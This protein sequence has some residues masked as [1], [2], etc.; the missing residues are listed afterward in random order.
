MKTYLLLDCNYLCH[1]AWHAFPKLSHKGIP[2]G[3]LFGFF[4]DLKRFQDD[5]DT[6][7]LIFCF[8]GGK[9]LRCKR[10]PNYKCSRKEKPKEL[11]QQIKWLFNL[12]PRLGFKNVWSH[13]GYEAD[14]LIAQACLDLREDQKAVIITGDH[15]FYQCIDKQVHV[16]HPKGNKLI[17]KKKMLDKYGV[18]P[19]QW[20]FIKALCGCKTDDIP[21]V[22][23]VQEKTA[24]NFI[25]GKLRPGTATHER[26][27][28]AVAILDRNKPLVNLPYPG[29]PSFPKKK[30]E[31][32]QEAWSKIARKLGIKSIRSLT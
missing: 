2:T 18:K 5:F 14:D 4:K 6:N 27:Q 22:P 13:P 21:G 11:K 20:A 1:R 10:F 3:V 28:G 17:T 19:R 32:D 30:N 23:G 9:S 16:F 29:T 8:D 31:Y 12:L 15:D 26:I 25:T 7:R 24:C